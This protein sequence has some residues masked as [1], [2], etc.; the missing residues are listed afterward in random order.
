MRRLYFHIE[1]GNMEMLL[2]AKPVF[3]QGNMETLLGAK[4]LNKRWVWL[5]GLEVHIGSKRI[6]LVFVM[7][8]NLFNHMLI[9]LA[10]QRG[11]KS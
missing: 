5:K 9:L 4:A 1:N 3:R 6:N 8:A 10:F 11:T 2:G 7:S